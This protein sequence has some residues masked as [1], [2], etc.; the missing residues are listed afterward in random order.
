MRKIDALQG[1]ECN[2]C[3]FDM[4]ISNRIGFMRS[5]HRLNVALGRG[6]CGLY[7]I[8]NLKGQL[9]ATG[10]SV[11]AISSGFVSPFR[12]IITPYY[13]ASIIGLL[14]HNSTHLF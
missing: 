12:A 10:S 2:I 5:A 4:T 14:F 11:M 13:L 8:G 3:I 6:Q 7:I 1:G 9:C